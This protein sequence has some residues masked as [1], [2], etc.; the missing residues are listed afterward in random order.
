MNF[1]RL[2]IGVCGFSVRPPSVEAKLLRYFGTRLVIKFLLM[3]QH[4]NGEPVLCAE[5]I[6]NWQCG[7][8][9][10]ASYQ[11]KKGW[12]IFRKTCMSQAVFT[13][14]SV[15]KLTILQRN[16][17]FGNQLTGS[18]A[19][20]LQFQRNRRLLL[21]LQYFRNW[22]DGLWKCSSKKLSICVLLHSGQGCK[23]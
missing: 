17:M 20:T 5:A 11:W 15:G 23:L 12:D 4:P 6:Y 13:Y 3:M 8:Q 18:S 21:F 22:S 16:Q 1:L 10:G 19:S 9:N 14:E 7:W 2:W